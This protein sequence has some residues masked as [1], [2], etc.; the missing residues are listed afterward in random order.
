MYDC[1]GRFQ[2]RIEPGLTLV[3]GA[4]GT[5]GPELVRLLKSAG[6][7]VRAIARHRPATDTLPSG[8]EFLTG[9]ICNGEFVQKALEGVKF[10][11]HLAA[12]LH[13]PNPNAELFAEY[14]RINTEGTRRLAEASVTAGVKRVVYF[15]TIAVYGSTKRNFVDEDTPPHPLTIYGETKLAGEEAIM[16]AKDPNSG[17]PLGVVLR[18]AATYGP[19]MKGNY[20]KLVKALSQ[21]WFIPVS[22]CSNRRTLIYELDATRAA[23]LAAQHPK[24]AGRIYNVSDGTIYSLQEIIAAIC[25]AIGRP[26][27]RMYLPLLPI[28]QLARGAD[29]LM[30]LTGHS[31]NLSQMVEKLTEDIAVCSERFGHELAFQPL[32]SLEEGWRQTIASL[33][34]RERAL[35][36]GK[37]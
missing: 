6:F 33:K 25:A 26:A 18:L 19:R 32:W 13:I 15:S 37:L 27:P 7:P 5:L 17:N 28:Q 23:L 36:S 16:A 31:L 20:L 22:D 2:D 10:V 8:V 3:T 12:K 11:F 35:D 4:T 14:R 21:Q 9:D 1:Q 24:A 30:R 34:E 29:G